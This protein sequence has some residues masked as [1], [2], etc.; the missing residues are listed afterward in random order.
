MSSLAGVSEVT[1]EELAAQAQAGS[2]DSFSE[3]VQR[4]R[5]GLFAFLRRSTA[6]V[7]D[8]EDLTQQTLVK[9]H[10][11]LHQ[12]DAGRKFS[13]WLY[14]IARR[15][16]L[17]HWRKPR[18]FALESEELVADSSAG[19]A[20][21][22]AE[23]DAAHNLWTRISGILPTAQMETLWCRYGEELSVREISQRTGRTEVHVKVLLHR[24]R[25]RLSKQLRTEEL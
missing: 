7:E 11:K 17:S 21:I 12:Y 15:L 24:A 19:P 22:V 8:A 3:L 10:E 9:A 13:P 4:H 20:E 6:T 18:S 16:S 5:P 2:S 25:V 23:H 1:S 14:A